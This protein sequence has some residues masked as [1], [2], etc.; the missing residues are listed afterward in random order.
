MREY[1]EV[2]KN[3]RKKIHVMK[4][5]ASISISF[6]SDKFSV[7][8]YNTSALDLIWN[9]KKGKKT[10]LKSL[11]KSNS[12]SVNIDPRRNRKKCVQV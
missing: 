7:A 8:Y 12:D 5:H 6:H 4:K 9:S 3:F 1:N 10:S 2:F 11:Y